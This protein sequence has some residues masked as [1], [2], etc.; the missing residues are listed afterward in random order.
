MVPDEH[1][2]YYMD[3][4]ALKPRYSDVVQLEQPVFEVILDD[5]GTGAPD[6]SGGGV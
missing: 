4:L 1:G 2:I 5:C 6:G 3:G